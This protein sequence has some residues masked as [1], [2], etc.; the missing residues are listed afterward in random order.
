M[1]GAL[2]NGQTLIT[3]LLEAGDVLGTAEVLRLLGAPI[4]R[5]TDGTWRVLGRGVGGE[6]F[7]RGDDQLN[8][9]VRNVRRQS[10]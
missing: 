2:A 7:H 5:L 8:G 4:E 1:F 9:M 6:A 3:G 10:L